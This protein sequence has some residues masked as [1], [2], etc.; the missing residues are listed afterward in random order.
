M[1]LKYRITKY[2]KQ[3]FLKK[4]V[5]SREYALLQLKPS[6]QRDVGSLVFFSYF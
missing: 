3:G 6:P 5:G 4:E 1:L 2:K